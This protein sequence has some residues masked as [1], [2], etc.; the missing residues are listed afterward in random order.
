MDTRPSYKTGFYSPVRGIDK[1][2]F[3]FL[4]DGC[5]AAYAPCLGITG[6][7]LPDLSGQMSNPTISNSSQ[8]LWEKRF[9]LWTVG[10]RETAGYFISRI[11]QLQDFTFCFWSVMNT[12]TADT[13]Y[14]LY[15]DA[16]NDH[17]YRN[18]NQIRIRIA[19]SELS[20]VFDDS[21][22][23]INHFS[24]RRRNGIFGIYRNGTLLENEAGLTTSLTSAS[25]PVFLRGAGSITNFGNIDDFRIYSRALTA[26]EMKTL[27][28]RRG[29]A[30][31]IK[32]TKTYFIMSTP[33]TTRRYGLLIPRII[34]VE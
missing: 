9:S 26:K 25:S 30:Y 12:S 27:S 34:G 16:T 24:F 6:L 31:E 8:F 13:F 5:V 7:I 20:R 1:P 15:W 14:P 2:K 22:T 4:W 3:P 28:L 10:T 11:P 29:I 19:G 17:I 33:V 21:A 18:Y 23:S 32:K